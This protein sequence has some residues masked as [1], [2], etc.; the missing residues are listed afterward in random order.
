MAGHSPFL[1]ALMVGNL[2][3]FLANQFLS[4]LGNTR[5][6]LGIDL[7]LYPNTIGNIS[8]KLMLE[9]TPSGPTFSIWGAIYVWQAIWIIYALVNICRRAPDGY[10]YN[11]PALLTST[12]FSLSILN[13]FIVIS[14][15][16][17]WCWELVWASFVFLALTAISIYTLIG[18]SCKALAEHSETLIKQERKKEI[19]LIRAFVQNGLAFYGAWCTIA[20]LLNVAT[21]LTYGE[22]PR[23]D[24]STSSTIALS[25][26]AVELVV[27]SISDWTVLDKY[28]RYIF[29]EYIVVIIALS[30][31]IIKNWNP[32]KRNS[33]FTAVL[34][35]MAVFCL[36]VKMIVMLWRHFRDTGRQKVFIPTTES[37][38]GGTA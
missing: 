6:F 32:E 27:F 33:I 21:A 12:F 37:T 34:L 9:I 28:T 17:L 24:Q 14:W 1:I 2:V 25:I 36:V 20:T 23:F 10:V 22:H 35:G 26:L 11:S 15:T 3:A 7:K 16:F 13:W 8:D 31:S 5:E 19:W 30:G 29:S 18:L 4:L 38:Q